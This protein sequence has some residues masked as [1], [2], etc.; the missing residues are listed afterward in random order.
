MMIMIIVQFS[1]SWFRKPGMIFHVEF[2]RHGDKNQERRAGN[3]YNASAG[4]P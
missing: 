1:F 4:E 2:M 3:N